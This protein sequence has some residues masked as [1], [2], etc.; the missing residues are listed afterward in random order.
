[1]S[2]SQWPLLPSTTV[3]STHEKT[4]PQS[5]FVF[6]SRALRI[7]PGHRNFL[8]HGALNPERI[9]T[10]DTAIMNTTTSGEHPIPYED[11]RTAP[12]KKMFVTDDGRNVLFTFVLVVLLFAFWGFCSGMIDVMD[13]HFQEELHL[14]LAQSAWVQFAHYLVSCERSQFRKGS[15]QAF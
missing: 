3:Q 4:A 11:P 7:C 13:K 6:R 2:I 14:T 15:F 1:M 8:P 5:Y 12:R 9:E 10:L